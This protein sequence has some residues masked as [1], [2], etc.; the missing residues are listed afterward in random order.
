[1]PETPANILYN[2]DG[3]VI[4]HHKWIIPEDN[5]YKQWWDLFIIGWIMYVALFVPYRLGFGLDDVGAWSIINWVMN[6]SFLI[7]VILTF[8]TSYY[9][10]DLQA[11]IFDQRLIA[12]RY[13]AL[14]FWI[15]MFSIL[16]I[17]S[18][19]KKVL[20]AIAAKSSNNGG[21]NVIAKFPRIARLY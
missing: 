10:S 9:D 21:I 15:D 11:N 7:D 4:A 20:T 12:K 13:L 18:L 16:P 3:S 8:F 1:M 2:E 5:K 14:W 6:F 19:M 17:D